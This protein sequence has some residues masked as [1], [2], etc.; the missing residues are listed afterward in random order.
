M[1]ALTD[2]KARA[3]DDFV[4]QH[5][6]GHLLQSWSWGAFRDA[7]GWHPRRVAVA[8]PSGDP[9][10]GAQVLLRPT[11]LGPYGYVPRGPVC[12]PGSP[13]AG[14]L[15]AAVRQ[16]VGR[17]VAVRYE[18]AW[19][20]GSCDPSD[21]GW[22]PAPTAQPRSTVVIDLR[23][24]EQDLL[25][26]MQQK[27]RYNLG[28]AER[29]GVSVREGG[30]ADLH[31]F[32]K[33]MEATAR[34]DGFGSRPGEYYAW[35]WRAF[36][37]HSHV[38]LAEKEGALLAALMTFHFG[39]AAVYLYG[40]SADEGRRDMPN[41]LLQWE[42]IRLAKVDGRLRYDLWGVPDVVG[43]AAAAGLDLTGVDASGD[44]LAGVWGFKRGLGGTV[45]RTVGGWDDVM[46]PLRHRLL[47]RLEAVRRSV[48][49]R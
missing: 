12:A 37:P 2:L 43:R 41:H 31:G 20:D 45:E 21:W 1:K 32:A 10:A 7:W 39:A 27:W 47:S 19:V 6:N 15:F 49:F 36:Q 26:G 38:L 13:E 33:L 17:A 48:A 35:A 44:A 30:E 22:V 40:A 16:S 42:A 8:G 11:P 3:W 34:R 25:D 24:S 23:S 46:S 5:T 4:A 9:I 29:R 18:P 14:A 28:L